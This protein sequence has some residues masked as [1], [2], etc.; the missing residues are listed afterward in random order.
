M[1]VSRLVILIKF[2][3]N[4]VLML[5]Y[6]TIQINLSENDVKHKQNLIQFAHSFRKCSRPFTASALSCHFS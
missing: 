1:S 5:P 4:N 6:K 2:L 3:L